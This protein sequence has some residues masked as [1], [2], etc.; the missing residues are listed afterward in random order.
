MYKEKLVL[1]SWEY[2]TVK[3]WHHSQWF[4]KGATITVS[5]VI[6]MLGFWGTVWGY[7]KHLWF[8]K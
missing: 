2:A 7:E 1:I 6:M 8:K 3:K 4:I 5:T